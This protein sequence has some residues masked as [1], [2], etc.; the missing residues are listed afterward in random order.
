MSD[1]I[2]VLKQFIT[3]DPGDPFNYY[4][5]GLEYLDE[6]KLQAIDIFQE[7]VTKHQD[8]LPT[9]YQL[10]KLYE[11]VGVRDQAILIFNEGLRI[12]K[13]QNDLKAFRELN[14]AL[15]ELHSEE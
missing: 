12:A 2:K 4:A 7:L 15:E 11:Q 3:D 8:Y 13:L 6:N 10:G 9:Y 5:L 14:A 1:R